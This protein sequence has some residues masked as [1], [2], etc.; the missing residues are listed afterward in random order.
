LPQRRCPRPPFRTIKVAGAARQDDR[1]DDHVQNGHHG[2]WKNGY[3]KRMSRAFIKDR[4]DDVPEPVIDSHVPGV[5]VPVTP[6]GRSFLEEQLHRAQSPAERKRLENLIADIVVLEPPADR[7]VIAFGATVDVRVDS[8]GPRRFTI[9][10][11][12]E[13]DVPAGRISA[14]SPLGR[15]LLGARAGDVVTWHR[16]VGDVAVTIDA[17]TYEAGPH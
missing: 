8:V 4:D 16:P 17:I 7:S 11:A 3:K 9:V 2:C 5:P 13:A 6:A 10:G 12:D 15:A 1:A 14:L